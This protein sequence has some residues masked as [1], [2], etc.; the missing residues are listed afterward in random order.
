MT[1]LEFFL[2]DNDAVDKRYYIEIYMKPGY[3][4]V[5]HNSEETNLIKWLLMEHKEKFKVTQYEFDLL[6]AVEEWN[7]GRN[8]FRTY[9]ILTDL[10]ERGYFKNVD[11][12]KTVVEILENC[13]VISNE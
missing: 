6:A 4:L 9:S 7:G 13:E 11:V 10:K 3:E 5:F 8:L 2:A 1:N 12:E